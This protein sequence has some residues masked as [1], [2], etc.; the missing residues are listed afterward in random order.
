MIGIGGEELER[1]DE[2]HSRPMKIWIR[3]NAAV[4]RG[5]ADARTFD[6]APDRRDLE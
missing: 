2:Q 1:H 4:I 6:P 5:G 3:E